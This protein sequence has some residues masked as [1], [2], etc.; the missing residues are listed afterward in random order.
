MFLEERDCQYG[1]IWGVG[2]VEQRRFWE[3]LLFGSIS[4]NLHV[5]GQKE[6][7]DVTFN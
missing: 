2:Q 4:D 7:Y 6:F 1:K 3:D 5:L